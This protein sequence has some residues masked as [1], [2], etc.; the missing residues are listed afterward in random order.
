VIH[1]IEAG[2]SLTAGVITDLGATLSEHIGRG[3]TGIHI[4]ASRVVEFDSASLE[5]LLDFNATAAERGLEFVLVQPSE[6]LTTALTITGIEDQFTLSDEFS[7]QPHLEPE[8]D[9]Q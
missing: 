7:T 2:R 9:D 6:V 3:A 8:A 1:Q 4:D 5:A